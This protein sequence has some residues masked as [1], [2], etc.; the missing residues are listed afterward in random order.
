MKDFIRRWLGISKL[1]EKD[2]ED[3]LSEVI[4][5]LAEAKNQHIS[6]LRV[7]IDKGHEREAQLGA[8]VKLALE[9][10]FYRPVTTG[11]SADPQTPAIP[12]ESLTDVTVFDET[13]DAEIVQAQESELQALI[14]EQN[15]A[16]LHKVA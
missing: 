7:L 5:T 14:Q 12:P 6:D 3:L 8:M 15:E 4:Q 11:K 13:A 2:S 9:H 10:Q 1:S 16:G